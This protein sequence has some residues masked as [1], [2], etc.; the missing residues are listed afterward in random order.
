M[1]RPVL[2]C[3]WFCPF[4]Q[5]SWIALV[6]KKVDFEYREQD[7]YNKSPEWLAINPRGLV[8][9]LAIGSEVVIESGVIN[10][11]IDEAWT[12]EDNGEVELALLP[13]LSQPLQRAK[14]RIWTDFVN[15]KLVPP[16]YKIL[17]RQDKAGQEEA[18]AELLQ[19][20]K[21]F[22]DAMSTST[23][24]ADDGPFFF[25]PRLGL[26]D[27][28]FVPWAL[29]LFVLREYRD[30]RLPADWTRFRRWLEACEAHPSVRATIQ[31][32][33]KLL[34]SYE[35]YAKNEAGS[36]VADAI[37]AGKPLP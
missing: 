9:A 1:T 31:D 18:A 10:E 14:A 37:N 27:I 28:A 22:T 30:F 25:G 6:H 24:A 34:A 33:D 23:T 21:T 2:Y 13:P 3:A 4:A 12:L 17:Q 5:K 20:L 7:P 8:P 11:F 36:L 35:R 16:F 26:V 32:R 15:K 29:R 19:G